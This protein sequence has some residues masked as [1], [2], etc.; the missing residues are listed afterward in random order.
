[1]AYCRKCGFQMPDDSLFCP[2]CGI[3]VE[4]N[5]VNE[6]PGKENPATDNL[7]LN[8]E[9]VFVEGGDFYYG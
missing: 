4:T 2:Q 9:M 5:N 1:M 6:S 7:D 8:I 3:R